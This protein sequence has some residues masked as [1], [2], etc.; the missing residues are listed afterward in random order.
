MLRNWGRRNGVVLPCTGP[1]LGI[2][3]AFA[4]GCEN[5]YHLR[6]VVQLQHPP[7]IEMS[8]YRIS[9]SWS[10]ILV[11]IMP[12]QHATMTLW[13]WACVLGFLTSCLP[14]GA[15][16]HACVRGG[17]GE[18]G[19]EH[20]SI[21]L[22]ERMILSWHASNLEK[23]ES[24]T[25]HSLCHFCWERRSQVAAAPAPGEVNMS[26]KAQAEV[27]SSGVLTLASELTENHLRKQ[28]CPTKEI[29]VYPFCVCLCVCV[30]FFF[31]C[32]NHNSLLLVWAC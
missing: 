32:S 2:M 23:G 25:S 29:T 15:G 6:H 13:L 14:A 22:A 12:Q 26:L 7:K 10:S 24:S 27:C 30:C 1:A 18:L 20:F 17:Q 5:L 31:P 3:K 4:S 21:E 11:Q 8:P 16:L 28:N 19:E 9:G